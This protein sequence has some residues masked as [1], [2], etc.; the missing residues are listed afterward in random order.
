MSIGVE[1]ERKSEGN[2]SVSDSGHFR[3]R[4]TREVGQKRREEWR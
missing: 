2:Q 1:T 3:E 4:V